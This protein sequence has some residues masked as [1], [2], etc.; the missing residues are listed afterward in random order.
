MTGTTL[1]FAKY[2]KVP[3]G[4]YV[5]THEENH[6]TNTMVERT[7]GAICLGPSAN[8]QGSYK[9]LFLC[10][11]RKIIRKQLREVPMPESVIKCVESI[12]L[13]DKKSGN[14]EFA[15]Q[16][17]IPIVD[18]DENDDNPGDDL[19]EADTAGLNYPDLDDTANPPGLLIEPE[20]IDDDAEAYDQGHDDIPVIP[21]TE[22][23][24]DNSSDNEGNDIPG[25]DP[26][27]TNGKEIP[28]V[29]P[30]ENPGVDPEENPGVDDDDDA[31]TDPDDEPPLMSTAVTMKT[32]TVKRSCPRTRKTQPRKCTTPSQ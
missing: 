24:T 32:A 19:T 29:H 25:V 9:F 31:D 7:R 22:T 8:F 4:A 20:E 15:D 27:D 13:R 10:T 28:G 11:G 3:F 26:E 21:E 23:V 16:N 1:D 5:E 2:Y 17:G 30:E 6:P 12:A 14:M 18:E